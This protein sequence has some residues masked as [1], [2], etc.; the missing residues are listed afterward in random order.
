MA[1]RAADGVRVSGH[2]RGACAA[3]PAGFVANPAIRAVRAD[4]VGPDSGGG[5]DPAEYPVGGCR[6]HWRGPDGAPQ[7]TGAIH[8]GGAEGEMPAVRSGHTV[9]RATSI[10]YAGAL[11]DLE[12]QQALT[13]GSAAGSSLA[14]ALIHGHRRT[15]TRRFGPVF[16]VLLRN[17]VCRGE[18]FR[19][20]LLP[21]LGDDDDGR[22][23]LFL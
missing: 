15:A 4:R 12:V 3:R 7:R 10:P 22:V 6:V 13:G 11:L 18:Q 8:A 17:V 16:D 9:A 1:E 2:C 19:R 14:S 20:G 5:A 21:G 23:E